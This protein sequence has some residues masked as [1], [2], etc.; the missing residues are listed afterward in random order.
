M[1]TVT[2]AGTSAVSAASTGTGRVRAAIV[3]SLL[4]LGAVIVAVVVLWQPWGERDHLSY[5]D[6]A[7]HRDAA[8]LGLVIDGL[9]FA[10]IAVAL[11][12]AVCRLAPARGSAWAN[13]G[14]VVTGLGG[15]AFCAGNV[16]FGSFAWYATN[17]DAVPADAG[18]ALMAYSKDNPGHLM[19]LQGAGFLLAT[20]GSLLLMVALWRARSVPRWL[21]IGYVVLTV[22]VF[23]L[24]GVALNI[25]EAIQTL[26]LVVVAFYALRAA[27]QPSQVT[28]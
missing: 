18:T 19:G 4:T 23:A 21:P 26:S 14:T 27:G 22:G 12:L 24:G 15:V 13:I 1:S 28:L 3:A 25:V 17:T 9:G 5:A 2:P 10:T 20:L 6:I 11:G 16:A 8:W 7:P